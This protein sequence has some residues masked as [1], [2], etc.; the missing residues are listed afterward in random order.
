MKEPQSTAINSASAITMNPKNLQPLAAVRS[1]CKTHAAGSAVHIWVDSATITYLESAL[2]CRDSN[3]RGR[4]IHDQEL[5]DI[6]KRDGFPE[7]A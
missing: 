7:K 4:H 3:H 5:E 1:P 2:I 6:G